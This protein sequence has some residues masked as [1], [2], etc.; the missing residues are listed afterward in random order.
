[1]DKAGKTTVVELLKR[2]YPSSLVWKIKDKPK[3]GS[4]E[5]RQKIK[6]HYSLLLDFLELQS[7]K[8]KINILDR[9][10]LSEL[11]YSKVKRGYEGFNDKYFFDV[12]EKR[13][14]QKEHL[15]IYC[16]ASP[17]TL[18]KRF[19][20]D[21]EDFIDEK[22]INQL[23]KRYDKAISMTKLKKILVDSDEPKDRM[24]SR[25]LKW[26]GEESREYQRRRKGR[27]S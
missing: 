19:K 18:K 8:D 17:E 10:F 5:E 2:K 11:V 22:E 23:S 21:K 6:N 15:L 25:V 24:K 27:H 4:K 3:N 26:V 13:I 9:F 7:F 14:K 16:Y 1:M 12:I 20:T